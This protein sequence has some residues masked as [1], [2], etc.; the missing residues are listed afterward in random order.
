MA[1]GYPRLHMRRISVMAEKRRE[2]LEHIYE[3]KNGLSLKEKQAVEYGIRDL[4]EGDI[5]Y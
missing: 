1:A 4:E 3:G 5:P 2:L